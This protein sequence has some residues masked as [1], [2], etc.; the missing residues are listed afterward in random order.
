[1]RQLGAL[2]KLGAGRF[3]EGKATGQRSF[4]LKEI[5]AL[6]LLFLVRPALSDEV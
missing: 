2:E 4:G 3:R 1:M 6:P 5:P